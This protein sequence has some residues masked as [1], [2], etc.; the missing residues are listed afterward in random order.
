[1]FSEFLQFPG[2]V[3]VQLTGEFQ[4]SWRRINLMKTT[5]VAL[6]R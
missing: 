4:K 6:V 2:D 1:V 3:T 5:S